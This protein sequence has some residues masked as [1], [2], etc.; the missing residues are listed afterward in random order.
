MLY[1]V[2][3]P[4]GNLKDITL[5]AL[6]ILKEVDLIVCEDT[7]RTLKLLNHYQIK[8][9]LLSYH[10]HNKYRQLNK[11]IKSLKEGK[12]LA[13]VSDAG[14]PCISDPGYLIVKRLIEEN[15]PFS[16][17]P[18]PF[19]GVLGLILSGLPTDRFV[20]EGF[21]PY[22]KSKRR[23]RLE[24]LKEEK[25]TVIIYESPHKIIKLLDS[26]LE[27]LGD[28]KI[29][30]VRELTKVYEEVLRGRVSEVKKILEKRNKIKGEFIVLISKDEN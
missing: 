10:E 28:R 3:T 23:K 26:I 17:I 27:I 5:R 12:N 29:A 6:D 25:R 21:L 13:L 24:E 8:K 19:A 11:I 7:R 20:F 9:P 16:I 30:V 15:L 2:G 4:I 1:I 14:L 18:G 22:K